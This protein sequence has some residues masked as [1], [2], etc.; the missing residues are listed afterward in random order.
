MGF[1]TD[2]RRWRILPVLGWVVVIY[3]V[4]AVTAPLD[5]SGIPGPILETRNALI[6]TS[7]YAVL[8][9]LIVWSAAAPGRARGSLL[10]LA[11]VC[12]LAIGL[13]QE[14]LQVLI[15]HHV[16]PVNSTFDL[17]CDS[18]GAAGGWW[19]AGRLAAQGRGSSPHD[20]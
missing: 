14:T 6:H 13:G 11:V 19:L 1:L 5:T 18:L 10:A 9:G 16:Y 7:G 2:R 12:T 4:T 8:G 17:L 3:L 20:S 15:R